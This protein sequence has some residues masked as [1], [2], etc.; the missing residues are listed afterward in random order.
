MIIEKI[1]KIF[2]KID[3]FEEQYLIP[4]LNLFDEIRKNN[5]YDE[6]KK[7][8]HDIDIAI[9]NINHLGEIDL[10][11]DSTLMAWQKKFG[12]LSWKDV[13]K[14][15]NQVIETSTSRIITIFK[16]RMDLVNKM[17]ERLIQFSHDVL[18]KQNRYRQETSEQ[19]LAEKA[20][21]S[22]QKEKLQQMQLDFQSV[23]TIRS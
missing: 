9:K 19:R 22:Q 13:K 15:E 1:K 20:W 21:I 23:T 4:Y 18:E 6:F 10:Q 3:S 8:S 11:F 2:Q 7:I 12:E 5:L 17:I 16:N 14:F